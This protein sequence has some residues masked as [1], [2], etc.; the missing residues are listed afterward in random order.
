MK[1]EMKANYAYVM[2]PRVGSENVI[3][4]FES[5]HGEYAFIELAD[6]VLESL[7]AKLVEKGL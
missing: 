5:G 4:R 3:L 2:P 7:K 1:L 6:G